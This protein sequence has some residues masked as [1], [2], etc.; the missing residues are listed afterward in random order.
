MLFVK[1]REQ[2]LRKTLKRSRIVVWEPF[3][4]IRYA[5][6]RRDGYAMRSIFVDAFVSALLG[7]APITTVLLARRIEERDVLSDVHLN[8]I[9]MKPLV[10]DPAELLQNMYSVYKTLKSGAIDLAKLSL[11]DREILGLTYQAVR[12]SRVALSI[13]LEILEEGLGFKESVSVN[14]AYYRLVFYPLAVERNLSA[15][16]DLYTGKQSSIYSKLFA[17][18]S[19]KEKVLENFK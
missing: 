18:D 9:I 17:I 5:I 7:E 12:R 19:V 6:L 1:P 10:K 8:G 4:E 11:V 14:V 2:V 13:L 16:Y 15:V 3:Y